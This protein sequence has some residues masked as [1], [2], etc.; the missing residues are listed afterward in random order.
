MELMNEFPKKWWTKSSID[1]L[2]KKLRDTSTVVRLT[3]RLAAD[4][5]VLN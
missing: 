4:H 1:R 5:E 2:V 3:D